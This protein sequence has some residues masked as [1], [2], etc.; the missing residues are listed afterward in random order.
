MITRKSTIDQH[1]GTHPATGMRITALHDVVSSYPLLD[2]GNAD[3]EAWVDEVHAA[4]VRL[5]QL[6]TEPRQIAYDWIVAH[7]SDGLDEVDAYRQAI[8]AATT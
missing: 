6:D 7:D 8:I 3:D 1:Q 2:A 5:E 4:R